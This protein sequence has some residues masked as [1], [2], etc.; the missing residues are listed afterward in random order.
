MLTPRYAYPRNSLT[1][2]SMLTP[3]YLLIKYAAA[4]LRT[5]SLL[6]NAA[7]LAVKVEEVAL[8]AVVARR[9]GVSAVSGVVG[10]GWRS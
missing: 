9:G 7:R 1:P 6:Q 10:D 3:I 4:S 2:S 5:A 8:L